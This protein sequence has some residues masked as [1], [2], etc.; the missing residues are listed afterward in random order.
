MQDLKILIVEDELITIEL[1]RDVLESRGYN[2]VG[3]VDRGRD[4]LGL[5]E[6]DRPD[7]ILMDVKI[8]G[9]IDGIELAEIV[10]ERYQIPVIYLTAF[11]DRKT[12]ERAKMTVSYGYLIKPFGEAELISNIEI[13]YYKHQL[14]N[15]LRVSEKRYRTLLE[16]MRDSVYIHTAGGMLVDANPSLESLTGYSRHEL[17]EMKIMDLFLD[18]AALED[19]LENLKAGGLIKNTSVEM[20][21]KDGAAVHCL[22]TAHRVD[23]PQPQKGDGARRHTGRDRAMGGAEKN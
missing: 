18:R 3:S 15:K 6:K 2:I 4:A 9:D 1:I 17:L 19:Y 20:R 10:A 22:I 8:K 5:I 12:V 11:A 7:L 13:A 16:S 23:R 21:R 14:D